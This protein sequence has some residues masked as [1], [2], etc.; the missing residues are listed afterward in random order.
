ML[1]PKRKQIWISMISLSSCYEPTEGELKLDIAGT[2]ARV[3]VKGFADAGGGSYDS[4]NV[5]K[6][7]PLAA[8]Q[9]RD[10]L[11]AQYADLR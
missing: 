11:K 6:V 1:F 5:S 2:D 4:H 9:S 3:D 8:A 7:L 10:A